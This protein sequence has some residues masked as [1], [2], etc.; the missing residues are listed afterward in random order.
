MIK[1]LTDIII[2]I[3]VLIITSPVLLLSIIAIKLESSGPALFIQERTGLSGK[4]FKMYKFRG[5]IDNALSYGPE[6]TQIDDPRI[7]KVG[8][9]LR[10]TS[11]DEIP[12]FINVLKGE[13]SIIGPRPEIISI[14][15]GYSDEQKKVFQFKPGITGYS[16][17]NGRQMLSPEERVKMEIDYYKNENI[18]RDV[19]LL[20]HTINVVITNKGNI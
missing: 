17:I 14:T 1:R 3:F 5:M 2:S 6:L 20:F 7:T 18:F 13:M 15:E 10:R 12:N 16:Q 11:I 9:F 8:K 4:K 19:T